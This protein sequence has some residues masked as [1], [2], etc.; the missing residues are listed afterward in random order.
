MILIATEQ[1]HV[2]IQT[3]TQIGSKS[4]SSRVETYLRRYLKYD[5]TPH[6]FRDSHACSTAF[7]KEFLFTEFHEN[8]LKDLA[9]RW[10]G[11]IFT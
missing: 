5:L 9:H 7:C 6:R 2:G 3:F 10:T 1:S 4:G 8:P 11:V